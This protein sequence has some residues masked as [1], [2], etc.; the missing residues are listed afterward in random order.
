M[1]NYFFKLLFIT[2]ILQSCTVN[3]MPEFIKVSNV[4]ISDY[5]TETITVT[6]DLLFHNPNSV[7]GILQVNQIKV[8]VNDIDL[9]N[10][11]SAN[12]KVPAKK[13]FSVPIVFDVPYKK[14]FKDKN[15]IV[16]NVLNALNKKSIEVNY[17]G[18]ITYKLGVFS[19]DYPVDYVEVVAF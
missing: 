13:E 6:S 16:L 15:N 11:N 1:I 12:F 17:K 18:N 5:S 8:W 2:I 4:D 3:E 10:L 9:G 7:G 14:I 19:Y